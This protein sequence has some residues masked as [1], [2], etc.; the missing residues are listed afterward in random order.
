MTSATPRPPMPLAPRELRVV[1]LL[2]SVRIHDWIEGTSLL[3]DEELA[4]LAAWDAWRDECKAAA[5]VAE[6]G[7]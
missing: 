5:R 7:I 3:N 4:V 2:H 6:F 1:G